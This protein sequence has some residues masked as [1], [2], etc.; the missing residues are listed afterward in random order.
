M[1]PHLGSSSNSLTE[2][3][4]LTDRTQPMTFDACTFDLTDAAFVECKIEAG[5]DDTKVDGRGLAV[6]A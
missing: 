3:Q 4:A 5:L 6:G 2:R 1:P